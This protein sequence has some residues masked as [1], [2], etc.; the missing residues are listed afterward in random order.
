MNNERERIKRFRE[1]NIMVDDNYVQ[2]TVNE[3]RRGIRNDTYKQLIKSLKRMYYREYYKKTTNKKWNAFC[4][5][6]GLY[7]SL[8]KIFPYIDCEDRNKLKIILDCPY[9]IKYFDWEK[10]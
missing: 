2:Q 3:R 7:Y 8:E 9:D 10:R 5:E 6:T 1:N 4:N